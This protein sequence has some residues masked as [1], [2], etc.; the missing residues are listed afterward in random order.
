[1]AALATVTNPGDAVLTES[2]NYAGIKRLADLFRLDIRGV[3][4]DRHGLRPEMLKDAAQGTR[5]GAILCSPTLHNP[6]NAIMPLERR[7]EYSSPSPPNLA[8]MS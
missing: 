3:P 5:V 1:M 4:M 6:T 8:P 2:L 7:Q